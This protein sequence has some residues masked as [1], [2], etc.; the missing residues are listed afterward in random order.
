MVSLKSKLLST[1]TFALQDVRFR[2]PHAQLDQRTDRRLIGV[3][4][5]MTRNR[6]WKGWVR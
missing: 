4:A 3:V 6:P 5:M 1:V 2:K